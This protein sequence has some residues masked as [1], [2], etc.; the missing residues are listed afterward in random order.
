LLPQTP[1]QELDDLR[2]R[3]GMVSP[4]DGDGRLRANGAGGR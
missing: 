2:R 1:G 4:G 3:I